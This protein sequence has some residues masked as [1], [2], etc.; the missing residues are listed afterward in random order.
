MPIEIKASG[1]VDCVRYNKN[2]SKWRI[3]IAPGDW[4]EAQ[5][6]L[7][8]DELAQVQTAWNDETVQKWQDTHPIEPP[9]TDPVPP[10]TEERIAELAAKLEALQRRVDERLGGVIKR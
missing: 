3:A 1:V 6:H 9:S 2:G 5:K 8:A 10:S 4:D 7:S